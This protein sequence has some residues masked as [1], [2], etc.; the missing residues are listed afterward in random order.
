MAYKDP[1]MNQSWLPLLKTLIKKLGVGFQTKC[2]FTLPG[3][4]IQFDK[5][6]VHMGGSTTN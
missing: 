5:H 4:M 1:V 6:V 2:I 3:G